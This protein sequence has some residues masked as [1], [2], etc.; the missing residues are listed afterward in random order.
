MDAHSTPISDVEGRVNLTEGDSPP[1]KP[2]NGR[3]VNELATD[4]ASSEIGESTNASASSEDL[5]SSSM[6]GGDP[7]RRR[8]AQLTAGD[9]SQI[10][11]SKHWRQKSQRKEHKIPSGDTSHSTQP[12]IEL[13]GSDF[14]SISTSDDVELDHMESENIISDD[15][16]T[17][18]T[19]HDMKHSQKR[20]KRDTDSDSRVGGSFRMSKLGQKAADRN[21][22]KALLVNSLLV[23]SWYLFS[24]S[25]S[26]VSECYS[27]L[28]SYSHTDQSCSITNGCSHQNIL[29]FI[30]HS[31]R[32]VCIWWCN[33][34]S[35]HSSCTSYLA[36]ALEQ[37]AFRIRTII[38]MC[39]ETLHLRKN[40]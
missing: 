27:S 7:Y 36:F 33:S 28:S 3:S 21:V 37:T 38:Y 32:L 12:P 5:L 19:K 22:L 15:E 17:G 16:E 30:F 18:L 40:L 26:I 6:D 20:R 10:A 24:L 1:R 4:R 2:G 9:R 34:V 29:T 11:R 14:S 31:S 8:K 39:D 13:Q 35:Q 25:I 23:A